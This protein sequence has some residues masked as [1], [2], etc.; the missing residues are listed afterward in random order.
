VARVTGADGVGSH[1]RKRSGAGEDVSGSVKKRTGER[2]CTCARGCAARRGF[3][4]AQA[5]VGVGLPTGPAVA[6]RATAASIG[7]SRSVL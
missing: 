1:A 6:A 2:V 3:V 5:Y 7:K 4:N